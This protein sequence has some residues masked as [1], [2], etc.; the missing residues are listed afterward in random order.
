MPIVPIKLA[1]NGKEVMTYAMLDSRS[2][3][4]FI[5][6]DIHEKLGETGTETNLIIKTINGSEHHS[7]IVLN[8]LTVTD[9]NG[10]NMIKLPRT[11][12]KE[13]KLASSQEIP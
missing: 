10:E 6:D 8:N 11:Y 7:S 4:T 5:R 9:I 1:A 13:E 2:T 12:T 3:G